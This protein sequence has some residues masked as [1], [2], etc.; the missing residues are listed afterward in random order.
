[1]PG[2][3]IDL[4]AVR[5]AR[6]EELAGSEPD[7]ISVGEDRYELP[8]E[9]PVTV[10]EGFAKAAN[11]DDPTAILDAIRGI[12]G[13]GA[14]ELVHKHKLTVPELRYLLEQTVGEYGLTLGESSASPS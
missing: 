6:A 8:V 1:M 14:N 10:L 9:L 12:L 5:A 7:F 2:K 11:G 3:A 4:N 13:D